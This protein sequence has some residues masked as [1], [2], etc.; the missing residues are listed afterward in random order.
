MVSSPVGATF[1]VPRQTGPGAHAASCE[2]DTGS[3]PGES[4]RGMA[5]STH[6]HLASRL[7][8][9]NSHTC[10]NFL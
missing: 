9:V 1:F 4:G 10:T 6:P 8:K 5:L 3:F 2:L 7:K